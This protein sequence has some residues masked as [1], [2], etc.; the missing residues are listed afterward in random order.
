MCVH[1]CRFSP[2]NIPLSTC[3]YLVCASCSLWFLL[4]SYSFCRFFC[5]CLA[6]CIPPK[7]LA[8]LA[9]TSFLSHSFSL[10]LCNSPGVIFVLCRLL[11]LL[12]PFLSIQHSSFMC[13]RCHRICSK[14]S[15]R[16]R[17][18]HLLSVFSVLPRDSDC[19]LAIA[20]GIS[21]SSSS[22]SSPLPYCPFL[23]V[24]L[25]CMPSS[26]SMF[27]SRSSSLSSELVSTSIILP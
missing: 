18:A 27:M 11:P 2:T 22:L 17:V 20:I 15:L 24:I 7:C 13:P 8:S 4:S 12:S 1:D 21:L 19:C 5:I 3:S 25:S 23:S 9:A 16:L 6:I 14:C 26:L 10:Y